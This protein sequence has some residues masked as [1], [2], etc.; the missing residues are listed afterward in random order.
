M[1]KYLNELK[2]IKDYEKI[3]RNIPLP[4]DSFSSFVFGH[5]FHVNICD[6]VIK[7]KSKH[8]RPACGLSLGLLDPIWPTVCQYWTWLLVKHTRC[9]CMHAQNSKRMGR[10]RKRDCDVT[11]TLGGVL[12]CFFSPYL[13]KCTHILAT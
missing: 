8:S 1:Y 7:I 6:S 3:K 9:T 12:S 2:L 4:R 5:W 13:S 11:T 10:W